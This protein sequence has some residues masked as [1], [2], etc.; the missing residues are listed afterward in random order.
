MLVVY[1]M[2]FANS[3]IRA[4]RVDSMRLKIWLLSIYLMVNTAI[5]AEPLNISTQCTEMAIVTGLA[6]VAYVMLTASGIK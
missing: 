4:E 3:E 1:V 5:W 6:G 2:T